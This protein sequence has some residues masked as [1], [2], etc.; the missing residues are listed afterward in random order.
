MLQLS[1]IPWILGVA[2][3]LLHAAGYIIYNVQTKKNDSTPNVVSWFIWALMAGLNA[4]SFTGVTDVPH[5]LQYMVD[6]FAAIATFL[7]ALRWQRF[8]WPEPVEW[9]VLAL[10]L[11]SMGLWYHYKDA[12]IANA[13]LLIPFF[14]SFWPTLDWV[15]KDLYKEK[16]LAWWVW[17][18]AFAVNLANNGLS[19]NGHWMSV[20]N[21]T[22]LLVCHWSIAHLSRETRKRR[23]PSPT[24]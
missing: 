24:T 23:F 5:A 2:A 7:L 20:V 8:D 14:I 9:F 12:S 4:S 17:T 3:A 19:W 18:A 10:C 22:I 21:P 11:V 13:T 16:S 6:T 15:R 1:W